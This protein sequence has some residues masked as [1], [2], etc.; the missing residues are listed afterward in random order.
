MRYIY[1]M[2]FIVSLLS[3]ALGSCSD[4]N[5][6]GE[7]VSPS[8]DVSNVINP[9]VGLKAKATLHENEIEL[10]WVNPNNDHLL[11][12]EIVYKAHG[13]ETRASANPLLI[14]AVKG[15]RE[16]CIIT[17]P[18]YDTYTI[19][20]T[21]LNKAGVRSKSCTVDV[22]P[23]KPREIEL[24]SLPTFLG[25]ADTLMRAMMDLMR[26]GP[27]SAW[28][29][30]YP[31][32]TGPYW[33]G[34]ATVW[35]QGAG[36]S[37]YTALREASVGTDLASYYAAIDESMLASLNYFLT[38]DGG[39]NA[40]GCY[41][42][43][44][45]DRFYDDNAW[46]GLDMIDLYTLTGKQKYLEKAVMVWEYLQKG[47]NDVAGG[48]IHWRE[49]P[50]SVG[51]HTCSTAPGTVL[52]AK[53]Y[54]ITND[55]KYLD[56]AI[57]LYSWLKKTLQDPDDY[58]YWDNAREV[59]GE[60][61]IGKEK[62]SYNTGQPMQAA[63]LLYKITGNHS[64]LTDAQNMA[65]AAYSRWFR[66]YYSA[67]LKESF[68]I[69]S[70][71]NTWFNAILFRG[72]IELYKTELAMNGKADRTYVSAYEKTMSHAWLSKCRQDTYLLNDDF[73]GNVSQTVWG[74]LTEG[75]CV[76]MLAR[77]ASLERDGI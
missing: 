28:N 55:A 8:D 70:G 12:V 72:Y 50:P 37:A 26:G 43:N 71:S 52:A 67:P 65:R 68:K 25:R 22:Q 10:S 76:E 49:L 15:K 14:D 3:C 46:I 44:G 34:D 27:R 64:Y 54:I 39:I 66:N 60:I 73:T 32:A 9:V 29:T 19:S 69:I 58:L 23:L 6:G 56:N 59:D 47:T 11:K 41:P 62:Y 1:K 21:A 30:S 48:G 17:V 38:N 31:K 20:V 24:I 36:F 35:G 4:D 57:E 18:R 63:V 61:Q 33:G 53:L 51:K 42:A 75:A 2:L 5:D 40:Y 74:I 16:T 45:N 13:T 7:I 77:L